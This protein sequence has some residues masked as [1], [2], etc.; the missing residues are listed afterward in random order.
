[1]NGGTVQIFLLYDPVERA[2]ETKGSLYLN[3]G[4]GQPAVL[5]GQ[6]ETGC[7]SIVD[8]HLW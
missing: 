3:H 4:R 1:M 6:E 5:P 7:L 2:L 8:L